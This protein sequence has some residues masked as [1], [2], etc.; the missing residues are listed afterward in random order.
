MW[1][2]G[3]GEGEGEGGP[4]EIGSMGREGEGE[5]GGG[6]VPRGGGGGEERWGGGLSES[7]ASNISLG[8]NHYWAPLDTD[9]I[10]PHGDKI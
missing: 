4:W 8:S 10:A 1:F 2:A 9:A 7:L 6:V 3:D 5:G